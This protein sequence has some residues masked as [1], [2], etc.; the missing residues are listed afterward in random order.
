MNRDAILALRNEVN[1]RIEHGCGPNAEAHLK[2]VQ[3]RLD[4]ILAEYN[5]QE[6]A[7]G[8]TDEDLRLRASKL[9]WMLENGEMDEA[10][11]LLKNLIGI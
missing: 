11:Q 9:Y 7:D 1:C 10:V 2:Y 8:L 6:F 4:K 3:D 5:L